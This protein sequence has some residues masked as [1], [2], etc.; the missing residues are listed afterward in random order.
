MS[1]STI[2][3]IIFVLI[4]IYIL[5]IYFVQVKDS[6][7]NSM[8]NGQNPLNIPAAKLDG[9][10]SNVPSNFSYSVWLYVNDWNYRY[11]ETKVVYGRM[12]SK[13]ASGSGDIEGVNGTNPCPA[14]VLS[15]LENDLVISLGCFPGVD[16][17]SQAE[18][19]II[20][21]S[22]T[23]VHNCKIQNVPIQKWFNLIISVYG[24]SLD[25]YIDGKLVKTCLLPGI[26]N[27]NKNADVYLTPGGGFSGWTAKFKYWNSATDPQKAWNIYEEGYGANWFSN[28]FGQYQINITISK[29]GTETTSVSL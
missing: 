3:L 19:A 12:G 8:L 20:S 2:L 22:N 15:P 24:R 28:L 4:I 23:V 11:G 1:F 21:S 27:V 16:N 5:Y 6:L 10:S 9:N 7:T 25:V 17:Q 29:D 14:V 18:E 26:A 13:S